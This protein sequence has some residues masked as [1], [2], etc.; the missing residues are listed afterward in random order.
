[1]KMELR[2]E[3]QQG[4]LKEIELEKIKQKLST[5]ELTNVKLTKECELK[6]FNI[7][8]TKGDRIDFSKF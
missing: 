4:S 2:E 6:V 1:M 5:A 3:Q 8:F 7:L